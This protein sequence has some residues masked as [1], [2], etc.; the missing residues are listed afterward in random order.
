MTIASML[1][2]V[3]VVAAVVPVHVHAWF[4]WELEQPSRQEEVL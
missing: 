3:V 4:R 1:V 2:E